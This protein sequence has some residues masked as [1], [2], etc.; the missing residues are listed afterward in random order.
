MPSPASV[1]RL[2]RHFP[3]CIARVP[4]ASVQ[5]TSAQHTSRR[6]VGLDEQQQGGGLLAPLS[7][8][9]GSGSGCGELLATSV[10]TQAQRRT[11]RSE[12]ARA[13]ARRGASSLSR[14]GAGAGWVCPP[15][16]LAKATL[17]NVVVSRVPIL[18]CTPTRP[19]PCHPHPSN[20]SEASARRR[21]AR[22]LCSPPPPRLARAVGRAVTPR[23]HCTEATRT[24]ELTRARPRAAVRPQQPDPPCP[25]DAPQGPS[26]RSRLLACC[27]GQ[28]G[29][30]LCNLSKSAS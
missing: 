25:G 11:G 1:A 24:P 3:R 12:G 16:L 28:P 22:R 10:R 5:P 9:S 30:A 6:L 18:S 29:A 19:T 15:S 23:A 17:D 8:C 7:G 13:R 27:R 26:R 14:V 21:R 20:S 4:A 2:A